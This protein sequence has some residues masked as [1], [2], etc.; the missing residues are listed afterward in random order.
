MNS[1]SLPLSFHTSSNTYLLNWL[2]SLADLDDVTRGVRRRIH[3]GITT[4]VRVGAFACLDGSLGRGSGTYL[5]KIRYKARR[6]FLTENKSQIWTSRNPIAHR[7]IESRILQPDTPKH[8]QT[9]S[10]PGENLLI[11]THLAA[12]PLPHLDVKSSVGLCVL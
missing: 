4:I 6:F 10:L 1:P 7:L 2:L 9:T 11:G 3:R 8:P 5:A 12:L